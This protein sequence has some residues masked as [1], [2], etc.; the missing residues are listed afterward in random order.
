MYTQSGANISH[1]QVQNVRIN[2]NIVAPRVLIS[3]QIECIV[4]A[5]KG[6]IVYSIG[7][8]Y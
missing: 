3:P 5:F 6:P 1:I 8:L 4:L 7:K 2:R